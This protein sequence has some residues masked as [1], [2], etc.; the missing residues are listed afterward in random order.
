VLPAPDRD[1]VGPREQVTLEVLEQHG[2]GAAD[3]LRRQVGDVPA[4]EA[5]PARRRPVEA[6][7]VT[8]TAHPVDPGTSGRTCRWSVALSMTTRTRLP[9]VRLR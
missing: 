8:S 3:R 1:V 5:D 9:A 2:D 4:V 6:R 7:L